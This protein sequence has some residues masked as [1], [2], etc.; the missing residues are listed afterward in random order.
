MSADQYSQKKM[1]LSRRELIISGSAAAGLFL[2]GA[3]AK[4]QKTP[5]LIRPPRVENEEKFLSL[6]IKCG[7]CISVCPTNV[8]GLADFADGFKNIRT[9]VMDYRHGGCDFCD[10]CI[11]VCPT[12]ALEPY[13]G[14]TCIIGLAELTEVCIALRTGGC[15]KCHDVCPY[16][17]VILDEKKRPSIDNEKC[18]GCGKC[19]SA[20]P[21]LVFQSF[22]SKKVRGIQVVP[23]KEGVP[24]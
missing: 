23:K 7:R 19:V 5:A 14:D 18:N 10:K 2:L 13:I 8:I 3:T 21:A 11:E 17:A 1:Q 15:T 9:P 6:C 4:A 16:D 20:C 22:G 12:G 24:S